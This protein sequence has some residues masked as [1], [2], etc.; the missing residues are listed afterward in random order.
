MN[1]SWYSILFGGVY[2]AL[3]AAFALNIIMHRRSVGVS[4]AWLVL[5]FAL[6]VAGFGC[7]LLFGPRRLGA[8]RLKRLDKLYPDY[9]QWSNH[10]TS[11]ISGT[12]GDPRIHQPHAGIYTLSEQA[13]GIPV[14]PC[15]NLQ[16]FH[17][18]DAIIDGILQDIERAQKALLW[19]FTSGIPPVAAKSWQKL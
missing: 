8:T 18:T 11:V 13:L 14:I 12:P 3:I 17:E 2:L 4:L 1:S 19:N 7:Y 6:P 9:Q 10:L 5:V 16:L 15:S